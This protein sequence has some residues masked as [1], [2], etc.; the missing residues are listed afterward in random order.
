M[1]RAGVKD[2]LSG[3]WLGHPLHPLATDAV[4]GSWTMA[5]LLDFR[6]E[7]A[8]SAD[9]LLGVGI[10]AA[11]PTAAAGLSDWADMTDER[12]RRMGVVHAAS[13]VAALSLNAAS[14]LARKAGR[15]KLGR[16]LTVVSGLPLMVGGFLGAHM[17][18]ARG[19]GVSRI[20]F[21][22]WIEDW[23]AVSGPA[24]LGPE[25]SEARA[26][27]L[28]VLARR[29]QGE[30]ASVVSG[31]CTHCGTRLR[32]DADGEALRCPD[33]GSVFRAADGAVLQGPATTPAARFEVRSGADRL[34]VR[35]P[36]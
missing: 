5:V 17:A 13:N 15:R 6:E 20:V 31:T 23:T 24:A 32:P 21:D 19:V 28:A 34:E 3:S 25:W 10:L 11:I 4:I 26:R 2:V 22:E 12:T 36:R 8:D 14:Y 27:G 7:S 29:P 30:A 16:R 18:Y 9:R 33:D 35:S 1:R